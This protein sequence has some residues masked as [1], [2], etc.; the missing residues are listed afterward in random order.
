MLIFVRFRPC[1]AGCNRLLFEHRWSRNLSCGH[2][3]PGICGEECPTD[4]C[5]ACGSKPGARVGLFEMETYNEANID[6]IRIVVLGCGHSFTAELLDGLTSPSEVYTTN[7]H[8]YFAGL[9]NISG[10]LATKIPKCPDCHHPAMQYITQ[11]YK[12][13]HQQSGDRWNVKRISG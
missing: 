12:P 2:Q 13:S 5:H 7:V 6:E 4:Y 10:A 9:A 3:C 1:Y 8:G 11:R